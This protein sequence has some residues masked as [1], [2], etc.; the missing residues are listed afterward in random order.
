MIIY[1]L[2]SAC[3]LLVGF[4][5]TGVPGLGLLVVPLMAQIFPAKESVGALLPLLI[6]GDVFAVAYYRRHAH[7]DK[8]VGL[9][10]AVAVGFAAGY[11]LM[12]RISNAQLKPL[13]G[14]LVLV[15]LALEVA[16]QRLKWDHVPSKWWFVWLIGA[17]A[18]F[19]TLIGNAA[20]PIMIIYLLSR[21]LNKEE[22]MGT[23]AWYF[24]IVNT[25]KVPLQYSLQWIGK[26][27]LFF[28]LTMIPF[29]VAGALFGRWV[30]PKIPAGPFVL[31]ARVLAGLAAVSL[32]L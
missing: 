32:F 2:G 20:G 29:V 14:G 1:I 8:L 18:G 12:D 9:F 17:L 27:T 13:L 5:K 31:L 11:F 23:G 21:G 24:L 4:T 7:W 3:A 22:F 15:L 30:M 16:R 28:D 10:P 26:N 19:T 6:V 25:A